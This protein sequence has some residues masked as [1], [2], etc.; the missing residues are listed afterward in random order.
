MDAARLLPLSLVDS[1]VGT[2]PELHGAVE[3]ARLS[4]AGGTL[5]PSSSTSSLPTL[6]SISHQSGQGGACLPQK[7][8]T[9]I[10]ASCWIPPHPSMQLLKGSEGKPSYSISVHLF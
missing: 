5:V 1:G 3:N 2:A 4:S 10:S 9:L 8:F 7:C 6:A